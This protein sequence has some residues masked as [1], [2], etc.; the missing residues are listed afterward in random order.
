MSDKLEKAF[1]LTE[2]EHAEAFER[3]ANAFLVDDYPELQPLGGKRDKGM[4]ARVYNNETGKTE[5]V[6][7][8]CVSPATTARTKVLGTIKKLT[9]NMPEVLI[10]CT[11]AVVATALDETKRELRKNYKITLEICDAPWFTQRQKTSTNRDSLSEQYADEVLAP[12][13]KELQPDRLYRLV[14]SDEEERI[15]VQYLRSRKS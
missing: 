14:L 5:L 9:D 13:I 3:Y 15:A 2:E 11:S 1:R 10:Y 7:Q 12:F 8:S 4:D 6:V